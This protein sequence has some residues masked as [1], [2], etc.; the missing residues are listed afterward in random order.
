VQGRCR[1]WFASLFLSFGVAA[2][3]VLAA[4]LSSILYLILQLYTQETEKTNGCFPRILPRASGNRAFAACLEAD[5]PP[6]FRGDVEEGCARRGPVGGP[7]GSGTRG[8]G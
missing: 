3:S 4:T 6:L 8:R 2:L 7:P 5:T 1:F